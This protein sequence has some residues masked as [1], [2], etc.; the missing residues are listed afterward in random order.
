M[1]KHGRNRNTPSGSRRGLRSSPAPIPLVNLQRE[2]ADADRNETEE[3]QQVSPPD[4]RAA[5]QNSQENID[6][7]PDVLHRFH[8]R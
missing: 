4:M 8:L 1:G 5:S 7:S 6:H 2:L 3:I